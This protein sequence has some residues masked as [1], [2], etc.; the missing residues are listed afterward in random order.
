MS[1]SANSLAA[2]VGAGVKNKVFKPGAELVARKI[3]IMATPLSA[4][5]SNVNINIP[6]LVLSPAQVGDESGFGGM[7]HR[8]ALAAF[9]G[10]NYS[11]PVYIMYETEPSAGAQAAGSIAIA[12]TSALKGVIYLYIAGTLYEV[13]VAKGDSASTIGDAI[14]A[15][16]AADTACPVTA[17]NTSGTVAFTS[18][19]K[20]VWGN[21]ISIAINQDLAAGQVLP[22]GVTATITAMTGGSG[23]P[24]VAADL[25]AALGVGSAANADFF[26]D[27][28]HGYVQDTT[29]LDALSA[30]VGEGNEYTGLYDR[31]VHRPFRSLTGDVAPG[32]AGLTALLALGAGRL[33]DRCNGIVSRP[34]SLSHPSEIAAEAMGMMAAA[35]NE[36]AEAN[37]VGYILSG[38]D[39]GNVARQA[40]NDWTSQYINRDT[41]VKAGISPTIV[42]GGSVKL[43]NVITFYHPASVPQTSNAYREMANISK[44]QNILYNKWL[45]YSSDDWTAFTI[46]SDKANVTV[47]ASRAKCRD[48]NDVIDT[49]LALIQSFAKNAWIYTPDYS[50]EALKKSGA[51]AVRTGGDGFVTQVP[52]ILSGVGNIIDTESFVDTSIAVVSA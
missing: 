19:S 52:Y 9:R 7:A 18:K 43:Q 34:G 4:K 24:T 46:V 38:V 36:R 5:A 20:G 45:A 26:T 48:L 27:I 6:K 17:V 29:V 2:G 22:S 49:E 14:V 23:A 21:Y 33:S 50:I 11:V 12:V 30:Y 16:L 3:L 1:M 47:A 28:V 35:N 51:V 15:V 37:Y 44:L 8:L 41:A 31:N 42:E 39:P 32:S 10:S 25:Q 40:G 13:A